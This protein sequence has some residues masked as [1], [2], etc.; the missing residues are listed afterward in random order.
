ME[1][2]INTLMGH[3]GV[4]R[5]IQD[6][7]LKQQILI[8]PIKAQIKEI[9]A[10][11]EAA[12]EPSELPEGDSGEGGSGALNREEIADFLAYLETLSSCLPDPAAMEY[13]TQKMKTAVSAMR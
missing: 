10:K 5:E 4:L 8:D 1:H 9:S 11:Q 2:I 13:F 12:L 6:L 3:R 7:R